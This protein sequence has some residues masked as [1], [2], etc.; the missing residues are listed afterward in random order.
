L[1]F[2]RMCSDV[3]WYRWFLACQKNVLVPSS[4]S[5]FLQEISNHLPMWSHIPECLPQRTQNL[6]FL[7]CNY[8]RPRSYYM[9]VFVV[10][11]T[12]TTTTTAAAAAATN[13]IQI[14]W[15]KKAQNYHIVYEQIYHQMC[16]WQMISSF[17]QWQFILE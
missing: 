1:G 4:F 12:T 9:V 6:M 7:Y 15:Y 16:T 2:C 11:T 10:T 3:I 14:L 17:N 13:L 5:R 8:N